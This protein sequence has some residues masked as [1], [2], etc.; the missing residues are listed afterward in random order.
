M[1]V[2]RDE[3]GRF[4]PGASGNPNGRPPKKASLTDALRAKADEVL[5]LPDGRRLSRAEFLALRVWGL[6]VNGE[7]WAAELIYNRLD[8]RPVEAA[9]P[10]VDDGPCIIRSPFAIPED[11]LDRKVPSDQAENT[12]P[13]PEGKP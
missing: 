3:S 13:P 9:A 11:V 4:L 1:T 5:P 8:G 6:A 2:T 12:G 10:E 7:R